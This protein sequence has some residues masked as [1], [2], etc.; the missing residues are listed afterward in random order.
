MCT[1]RGAT[2][3][4]T[5][6]A[7]WPRTVAAEEKASPAG[8]RRRQRE[9]PRRAQLDRIVRQPR[10]VRECTWRNPGQSRV[11]A[12]DRAAPR[13]PAAPG[14]TFVAGQRPDAQQLIIKLARWIGDFEYGNPTQRR[15]GQ[16]ASPIRRL[17]VGQQVMQSSTVSKAPVPPPF[18]PRQ[19]QYLAFIYAYSRI[20]R[21]PPAEA[22]MQRYFEVS[23]PSVHQMVLTLERVGLIRRRSG[24]ARSI[25]L[26]LAPELLPILR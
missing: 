9:L 10:T 20:H 15:E 6:S 18:T 2:E 4:G 3:N 17:R 23:P 25:E 19:G 8:A 13:A 12:G 21:R 22:D 5:R 16:H 7:G 1:L 24:E 11:R 14:P 26:L